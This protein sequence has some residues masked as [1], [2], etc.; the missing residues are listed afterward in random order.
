MGL[1]PTK[2][3]TL[4][5]VELRFFRHHLAPTQWAVGD[6]SP[7]EESP[8][9][10]LAARR[11]FLELL[12]K[13]NEIFNENYRFFDIFDVVRIKFLISITRGVQFSKKSPENYQKCMSKKYKKKINKKK[14]T[15]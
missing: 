8:G 4:F 12:I 13:I 15:K 14:R 6:R 7:L 1:N 10:G 2:T 11:I 5:F 3:A 9:R